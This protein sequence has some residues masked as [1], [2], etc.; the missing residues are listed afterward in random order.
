[1]R[2]ILIWHFVEAEAAVGAGHVDEIVDT[3][4]DGEADV[5]GGPEDGDPGVVG[6]E[7]ILQG[8]TNEIY[9]N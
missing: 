3:A 6:G 2:T 8:R 1:M 9:E 4:A 5:A 7:A